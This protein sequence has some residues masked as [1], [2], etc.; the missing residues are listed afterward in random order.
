MPIDSDP[1]PPDLARETPAKPDR[2]DRRDS[3]D[4]PVRPQ[5]ADSRETRD[6]TEATEFRQQ[7]IAEHARYQQVVDA[8]YQAAARQTWAKAVPDLRFQ[9]RALR[10]ILLWQC[11]L[12][13]H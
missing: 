8:A 5:A 4:V 6:G 7:Q 9:L 1:D 11:S 10:P 2:Q 12:H 13:V 3:P